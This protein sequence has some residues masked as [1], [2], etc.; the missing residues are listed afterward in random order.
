[1]K[2]TAGVDEVGRG[3]LMGPVYAA[4]VI[5]NRSIDIKL[6]KDSKSIAK[7]KRELLSNYIK[8]NSTWAVGKASVKE[9]DKINI[10]QASLLAMKRAVT[11]L[12]IKPS[13]ILIDGNKVPDFKNYNLKDCKGHPTWI[14]PYEWLGNKDN[15]PLHLI[16]N[17]PEYR[18][19]GQLDHADYSLK[20]KIKD[21]EPVLINSADAKERNIENNDIVLIFNKRG[22][23][24]A[25]ARL[26]D[27]VSKG[28]LVL[29]TGAWFDPNYE[30]NAD[31]HGNPNVLTKDIGTSLLSQ[32]PTSHTCLVEIRKAEKN[33]IK[34][35]TI[36]SKPHIQKKA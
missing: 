18:L 29:S 3:S 7:D 22:R 6:L 20:N 34:K 5:L 35:V 30:I 17:Q 19:H 33:E 13:H 32:G 27:E 15:F 26:S 23:V 14:E 12:K 25:G 8:K 1:M 2:I 11:K 4:A 31:L 10:L 24:F 9:I 16:S 28:V 36:F 21:R